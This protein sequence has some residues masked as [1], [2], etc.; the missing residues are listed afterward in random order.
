MVISLAPLVM[1]YAQA[2][3]GVLSVHSRLYNDYLK[4]RNLFEYVIFHNFKHSRREG[5]NDV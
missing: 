4:Y 3:D 1:F 5:L 2:G